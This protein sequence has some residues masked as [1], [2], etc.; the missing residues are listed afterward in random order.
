MAD[1][2]V[3]WKDYGPKWIAE[4]LGFSWETDPIFLSSYRAAR[5]IFAPSFDPEVVITATG[6][7]S[8]VELALQS[9]RVNLFQLHIAW[10]Y[11]RPQRRPEGGEQP[12]TDSQQVAGAA[13]AELWSEL[14]KLDP[15]NLPDD[16]RHLGLDG[17]NVHCMWSDETGEVNWFSTWSPDQSNPR[18]RYA[19]EL[20]SLA[21]QTFR[22]DSS[23]DL[24]RRLDKYF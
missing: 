18:A 11:T 9:A 16:E 4:K 13:A 23:A 24:L 2:E 15:S 8:L 17:I 3:S 21:H 22:R 5:V 14:R 19:L 6:D 1:Q 7:D 20:L 12:W 10:R